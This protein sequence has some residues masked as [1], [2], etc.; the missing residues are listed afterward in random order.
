M[1]CDMWFASILLVIFS[2]MFI[3]VL[4]FLV[5]FLFYGDSNDNL[6]KQF[7]LSS[8]LF[9]VPF[10]REKEARRLS[11][12]W[13]Q[14]GLLQKFQKNQGYI[15]RYSLW[16]GD[17]PFC[18]VKRFKKIGIMLKWLI[19]FTRKLSGPGLYAIYYLLTALASLLDIVLFIFLF[20]LI[21]SWLTLWFLEYIY[22]F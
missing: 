2:S 10:E 1:Q 22:F 4:I 21:Q 7:D 15:V 17:V 13:M 16:E 5:I 3:M 8:Q 20:L 9:P 19:E 11:H 14:V 12:D 6:R 18:F